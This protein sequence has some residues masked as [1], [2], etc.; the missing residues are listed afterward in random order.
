MDDVNVQ[1]WAFKTKHFCP[2]VAT[3]G[4][5]SSGLRVQMFLRTK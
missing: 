2:S 1:N 3:L 4:L 5:K